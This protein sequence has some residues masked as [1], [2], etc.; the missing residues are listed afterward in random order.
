M[1]YDVYLCNSELFA[2]RAGTEDRTLDYDI[3]LCK[4]E[5]QV[6]KLELWIRICTSVILNCLPLC[7]I[8][9]LIYIVLGQDNELMLLA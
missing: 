7:L 4:S 6:L 3:Y 5:L 8:L 1:D 9:T 2:Y